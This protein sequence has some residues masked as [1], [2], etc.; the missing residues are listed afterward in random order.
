MKLAA[1]SGE[2]ELGCCKPFKLQGVVC[3]LG[4]CMFEPEVFFC[5]TEKHLCQSDYRASE[6]AFCVQQATLQPQYFLQFIES[7]S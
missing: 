1:A 7:L 3:V 4:V 5:A 2:F 6:Y